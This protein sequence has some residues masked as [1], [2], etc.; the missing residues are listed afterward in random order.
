MLKKKVLQYTVFYEADTEEGGF[1]ASVPMLP[2]CYSQGES[3]EE[4]EKNIKEAIGAYLLSLKKAHEPI[5]TEERSYQ[6]SVEIAFA[7]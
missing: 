4:A 5:P 3:L 1:V 2:G 7:S 6:G